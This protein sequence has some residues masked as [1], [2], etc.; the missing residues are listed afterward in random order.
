MKIKYEDSVYYI[1]IILLLA[2]ILFSLGSI[3]YNKINI[4][5]KKEEKTFIIGVSQSQ[6]MEPWQIKINEEIKKEASNYNNI[7]VIYLDAVGSSGKQISD[8]DKLMDF[9]IDLLIISPTNSSGVTKKVSE[10]YKDIP[11]IVLDRGVEG[12]DY[13]LYIGPDNST[14]GK[15]V[16]DCAID[17]LGNKGG[18]IIEIKGDLNSNATIERSEGFR[19][20]INQYNNINL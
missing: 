18:N 20:R 1:A 16:G 19:S 8:I 15:Q 10:V 7:Q 13:T 12:Y 4:D 3:F 2:F 9:D 14:L 17:F 11:V 5:N 6:L